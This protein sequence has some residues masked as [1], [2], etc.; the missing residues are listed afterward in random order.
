VFS[1]SL[2]AQYLAALLPG[3]SWAQARAVATH[4]RIAAV[5]RAH[6]WGQVS[7]CKPQAGELLRN[8]AS[9]ESAS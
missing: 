6:G 8:L 3:V 1:S 5:L 9:L 4:E 2:A 7:I